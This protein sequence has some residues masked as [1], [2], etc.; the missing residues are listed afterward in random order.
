MSEL[1]RSVLASA[2]NGGGLFLVRGEE[3]IRLDGV[4]TTGIDHSEG[5]L[6][7]GEQP[8]RLW[9]TGTAT[10]ELAGQYLDDVHDVLCVEDSV[11]VVSTTGNQVVE[12]NLEGGENRRWV[13]PGEPDSRHLNCLAYWRG[14]VVFSS[15]G[16]F[17][18]HRGYKGNTRG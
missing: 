6:L 9:I 17:A 1:F 11:Y 8:D 14:E 3:V 2:P 15:F 10:A 13:F 16:E 18:E 5:I 12:L 4:D 7:R